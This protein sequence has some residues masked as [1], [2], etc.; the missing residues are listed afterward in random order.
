M[1]LECLQRLAP[2][3][4]ARVHTHA[5]GLVALYAF[6]SQV[7]GQTHSGSDIDLAVLIDEPLSG[8]GALELEAELAELLGAEVDVVDLRRAPTVLQAQVVS[9]GER[10]LSTDPAEAAR[11][12]TFVFSSYSRL[13][14]ERREILDDI[15]ARGSVYGG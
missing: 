9:E 11:F 15:F 7:S 12:E 5:G 13:N 8:A 14:E 2:E 3:I 1:S 6:G 4:A 10:F